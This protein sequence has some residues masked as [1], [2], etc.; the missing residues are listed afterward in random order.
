MK[1]KECGKQTDFLFENDE[2]ICSSCANENGYTI[3]TETGKYKDFDCDNI[4][5]DCREND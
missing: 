3:C 4:C 2:P 1:C 5:S